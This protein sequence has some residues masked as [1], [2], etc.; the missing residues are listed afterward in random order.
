MKQFSK[1]QEKRRSSIMIYGRGQAGT[2]LK[3]DKYCSVNVHQ[4][5]T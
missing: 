2:G 1:F 4:R 3:N 5:P